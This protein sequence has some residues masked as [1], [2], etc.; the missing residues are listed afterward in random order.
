MVSSLDNR[1]MSIWL[2]GLLSSTMLAQVD[3]SNPLFWLAMFFASGIEGALVVGIIAGS[4][5]ILQGR[6]IRK[7]AA[8]AGVSVT[9]P[10]S[11]SSFDPWAIEGCG[12]CIIFVVIIIL[13]ALGISL[14]IIL[15]QQTENIIMAVVMTVFGGLFWGLVIWSIVYTVREY[16]KRQKLLKAALQ[17]KT[18]EDRIPKKAE[19]LFCPTCGAPLRSEDKFCGNC[20]AAT[21]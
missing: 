14:P 17:G 10:K 6:R 13:G 7:Q 8:E 20:G 1:L 3:P 9:L 15:P 12:Y 19:N 2:A 21:K 5:L 16:P 4:I 18:P 11:E